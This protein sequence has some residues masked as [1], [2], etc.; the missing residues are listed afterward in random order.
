[1]GHGAVEGPAPSCSASG[2]PP[3]TASFSDVTDTTSTD[4]DL[5]EKLRAG[6][7]QALS[8]LIERHAPRV[9]RFGLKMC[10]DEEDAR[11]VLQDTLL[12]AARQLRQFRGASALSTWLYAIARSFCIKRRRKA[13]SEIPAADEERGDAIDSAPTPEH[14]AEQRELGQALEK[15][16]AELEPMYREVLL[17]RDVEGLSAAEVAE[18]LQIGVAAV[19]S[20]LHR[21]RAQVRQ[22]LV[23]WFSNDADAPQPQSCPDIVYVLSRYLENEVSADTCRDMEEHVARCPRCAAD[24]ESLRRVLDLCHAAPLPEVSAAVLAQLR[25]KIQSLVSR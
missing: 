6:D 15:A 5:V 22:R 13:G 25:E 17:L 2:H 11:E 9:Y 3:L 1:M 19:K 18:V 21:A 14:Q 4:Q 8:V 23:P 16:I 24:C 20:R 12:T 10:R 7:D